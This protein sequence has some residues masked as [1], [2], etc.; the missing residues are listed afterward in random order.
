MF[1]SK[2]AT[3]LTDTIR[4]Y[5]TED[6]LQFEEKELDG[7]P[8]FQFGFE[9]QNGR[10]PGHIRVNEKAEQVSVYF[11]LDMMVPEEKRDVAC[12]Y[13][14][15]A[16]YGLRMGNMEMDFADGEIRY[17]S[18]LDFEGETLSHAWLKHAIYPAVQTM[19]RY[20]PGLMNVLYGGV[21]PAEAI[22]E[23][24]ET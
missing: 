15:R 11:R 20:L 13:L 10:Y 19:D 5:F 1:E 7:A 2:P 17:K 23:I 21:P 14:T 4:Q 22:A 9:A 24:E 3:P 6:E 8:I 12:E 16:N 18:S